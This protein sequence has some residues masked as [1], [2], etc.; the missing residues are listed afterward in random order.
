M[1]VSTSAV[2]LVHIQE[3]PSSHYDYGRGIAP[4][5]LNRQ[6]Q[7][8]PS[9]PNYWGC[10]LRIFNVSDD[11]PTWQADGTNHSQYTSVGFGFSPVD[12]ILDF[13]EEDNNSISILAPNNV[14]S[15]IDYSA[16]SF[17]FSTQCQNVLN[18]SCIFGSELGTGFLEPRIN[19]SCADAGM[20]FNLSGAIYGAA[21][22]I[23]QFDFHKYFEELPPFQSAGLDYEI[24]QEMAEQATNISDDEANSMFYNPWKALVVVNIDPDSANKMN[25]SEEDTRVIRAVSRYFMHRC[26]H[27]GT[28]CVYKV[29]LHTY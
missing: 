16:S 21:E 17:G 8:E 15:D 28:F 25:I 19:F 2:D 10:G 4:W 11:P 23:Y 26:D 20:G 1:H 14:P 9:N 5:C 13:L 22:Q 18:T 27:T 24:T 29:S 12:T 6:T 7:G 3:E